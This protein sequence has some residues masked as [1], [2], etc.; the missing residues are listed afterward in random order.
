MGLGRRSRPRARRTNQSPG[1]SLSEASD[2][3][4]GTWRPR[5]RHRP[6]PARFRLRKISTIE[7]TNIEDTNE[8]SRSMCWKLRV[9]VVQALA[10]VCK[11]LQTDHFSTRAAAFWAPL[12]CNLLHI[13]VLD[14][15]QLSS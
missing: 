9:R 4:P 6:D 8:R 14:Q 11:N 10:S 12:N 7:D 3:G 2:H 13:G 5:Q 1:G 15:L